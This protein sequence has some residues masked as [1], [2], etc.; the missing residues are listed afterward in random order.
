MNGQK[1][2]EKL[3]DPLIS[4]K[5]LAV[6]AGKGEKLFHRSISLTL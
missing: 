3:Q 6:G 2:R 4:L 5:I 1:W